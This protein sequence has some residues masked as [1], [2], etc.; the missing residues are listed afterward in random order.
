MGGVAGPW[1]QRLEWDRAWWPV[2][3]IPTSERLR[4]EDRCEFQLE[5][6]TNVEN[7][8]T[9]VWLVCVRVHVRVCVST[10][11]CVNIHYTYF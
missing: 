5:L 8:T 2:P 6:H 3:V 11:P 1:D 9:Y 7:E 10:C 4:Q